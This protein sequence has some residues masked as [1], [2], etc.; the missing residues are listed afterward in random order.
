MIK[1][2]NTKSRKIFSVIVTLAILF[3]MAPVFVIDHFSGTAEAAGYDFDI[4]DLTAYDIEES[5]HTTLG[6]IAESGDEDHP[7][8]G[9]ITLNNDYQE[10]IEIPDNTVVVIDLN[11]HTLAPAGS[12]ARSNILVYGTLK[13]I[14]SAGGGMMQSDGTT[15]ISAVNVLSG[16]KLVFGGGTINNYYS[17]QNGAGIMV[18]DNGYLNMKG[19]TISH[20]KSDLQGGGI[21]AY[22]SENVD[23]SGG[24][25]IS[26]QATNGGG[27]TCYRVN[28]NGEIDLNEM[29]VSGNTATENGGGVYIEYASTIHLNRS[30]VENN[31]AQ[32]GGGL[33]FNNTTKLD[34]DDNSRIRSN[35]A[36]QSGGGIFFFAATN[37]EGSQLT[38]NGGLVN[39]NTALNGSGGGVYFHNATPKS[40]HQ[41][42][43]NGGQFN[44]NKASV[45][46]GGI[47]MY[48]KTD[49]IINNGTVNG[50]EAS[51]YGGG[52]YMEGGLSGDNCSTFTMNGGCVSENTLTSESGT[53]YG[54]GLYIGSRVTVNFNSGEISRNTNGCYGGGLYVGDYSTVDLHDGMKI[55]ENSTNI[56]NGST[57]GSGMYLYRCTLHMTGGE[58]SHNTTV[59]YCSGG[60]I[61]F[62]LGSAEI[63]GGSID[64]HTINGQGSGIYSNS[65]SLEVAGTASISDNVSKTDAGGGVFLNGGKMELYGEAVIENNQA[66]S[67]AGI[68]LYDGAF[69]IREDAAIRN[70]K[71]SGAGGGITCDRANSQ[72]H[73]K[74]GSITGNTA[75]S[76]GGLYFETRKNIGKQFRI[77]GGEI[78]GNKASNNGGGI[79]FG[80][81]G[82]NDSDGVPLPA[83]SLEIATNAVIENNTA[84]YGGGIYVS[85]CARL[86]LYEGGKIIGNTANNSGGGVYVTYGGYKYR[87]FMN[88]RDNTDGEEE[89]LEIY[90]GELHD[91]AA[92]SG[93][94]IYVSETVP[95]QRYYEVPYMAAVKA[96]KMDN[97]SSTAYW[98]D[99]TNS[100][101]ITA[102]LS[103]RSKVDNNQTPRYS[104]YTFNDAATGSAQIDNVIYPNVQAAVNAVKNNEA[105]GNDIILI[106][107]H[108]ETVVIP[109]GL[110]VSLDLNG[111]ALYGEAVSVITV[112]KDAVFTLKD[113]VGG[114]K[115]A[116]GKGTQVGTVKWG[117]GVY[118][119]GTFQ[120]E[121]GTLSHNTAGQGSAVGVNGGT[122]HMTG[123]TIENNRYDANTVTVR[124]SNGT[125]KMSD[126]VMTNNQG[127]GIYLTGTSSAEIKDTTISKGYGTY[128]AAVF[129]EGTS[130]VHID[131]C[132]FLDNTATSYYGTVY[133]SGSTVIYL[134]DTLIQGNTS[135]LGAGIYNNGGKIHLDN[136]TVTENR[137]TGDGGGLYV[138]G[139]SYVYFKNSRI[140]NNY[141]SSL[142]ADA[143]FDNSAW[144]VNE[145]GDGSDHRAVE[146][147]G[148]ENYD[149]WFD[150]LSSV[151]YVEDKEKHDSSETE[152]LN[153]EKDMINSS[154]NRIIGIHYLKAAQSPDS[155]EPVAEIVDTGVLYST[156]T[157]AVSAASKREGA[158]EIKLLKNVVEK[159]N[160]SSVSAQITLDFNGHTVQSPY[161]VSRVFY[162]THCDVHFKDTAGGGK[163]LPPENAEEDTQRQPRAIYIAGGKLT[164]EDIEIAGFC[165]T[166]NGGAIYCAAGVSA[167]GVYYPS[168]LHIKSGTI[169]NNTTTSNGGAIYVVTNANCHTVFEMTGGTI[170]NNT[171]NNGGGI[172][173]DCGTWNDYTKITISGGTFDG[174]TAKTCSGA[175]HYVGNTSANDTDEIKLYGFTMKNNQA[176]TYG[177]IYCQRGSNKNYP[178]ILGDETKKTIF[179]G[180]RSRYSYSI[181]LIY[182]EYGGTLGI[183]AQNVEIK[184]NTSDITTGSLYLKSQKVIVNNF[185]VHHNNSKGTDA[186]LIVSGGEVLVENSRFHH[187]TSRTSSAGLVIGNPENA[188]SAGD[189]LIKDCV[190]YENTA[191]SGAG[192]WD[193]SFYDTTYENCEF[194]N[195]Y[196]RENGTFMF[197]GNSGGKIRTKN[198]N[199]C[200]FHDNRA[201]GY[202]G[203]FATSGFNYAAV[204]FNHTVLENNS[205]SSRGGAIYCENSAVTY[206]I[207]EGTVIKN[208]TANEGGGICIYYG[209]LE[210][211]NGEISEN[212][213]SSNGGGIFW[214]SSN[215]N[216]HLTISGGTIS[217]NTAGSNAG[218]L[219]ASGRT[220][221]EDFK[222]EINLTGGQIINN[223]AS[224]GGGVFFYCHNNSNFIAPKVR[225]TGTQIKGNAA[226]VN[227]GGIY[228]GLMANDTIMSDNA[229]VTENTA[230]SCGGGVYVEY[231]RTDFKL[232]GGKL[233]GNRASLGNDAYII[234]NTSW[235]NSNLYLYKASE[236]F[237]DDEEYQAA[238]WIDET[239]GAVYTDVIKLRPLG[240]NYPYT[241]SYRKVNQIVA[242]YNNVEYTSVTEAIEAVTAS[243]SMSGE[244]TMVADSTESI[245]VA[246][247]VNLKL[248]LNGHTLSGGG[249]STITNRGT[250]EI[251]DDKKTVTVGDHT[252]SQSDKDG[253]IT[254]SASITGG[255]ICVK[256]GQV[257]LTGGKIADCIAGGNRDSNSYGGAA[258]GI[259][260]GEFILNGGTLCDNIAR[261]GSAVLVKTPSAT[262]TMLSGIIQNNRTS[263][264]GDST[265]VGAGGG[266]YNQGGTVNIYGGTISGNTAYQGGG[267]YSSGGKVNVTGI[268]ADEAPVIS[269]NIGG[270][271]GGGIY[272]HTGTLTASN[273]VINN[274]RTTYSKS[275][276][277]YSWQSL[278]RSAGGGIYSYNASVNISD[279]TIITQNSAVRGGGIYQY[280]GTVL[281]QGSRT[282]ITNNTAQLGGGCAQSPLPGNSST[283]MT[284]SEEA[285]VYGNRSTLTASGNDFYS[286]WEG[287]NTYKQQLGN[288]ATYTP[289]LNLIPAANMHVG[290]RY[291]VW[292]NDNYQGSS[293]TG[294]NLVSG[295][296]VVAEINMGND[297]QITAARYNADSYS[298]L[299]SEFVVKH[300]FINGVT[301]GTSNFDNGTKQSGQFLS[302]AA[303][304]EKTAKQLLEEGDPDAS[305]TDQVYYFNEEAHHYIRYQGRLYEQNQAVQWQPGSDSKKDNGIVRSF[306]KITY[307]VS[308][309]FEGDHQQE[310]YTRD[311]HCQVRIKAVLPCSMSEA[312]FDTT[313]LQNAGV[314]SSLDEH[315]N[316]VQIMTGYWKK[317]LTPAQIASGTL[318]ENIVINVKGMP[319][320]GLIQPQIEMWFDGNTTSPH[321]S[322]RAETITVSAAPKYNITVLSNPDLVHV[323]NYDMEK[324]VEVGDEEAKENDNVLNGVMLG[325]GVTVELYN[326]PTIKGLMGVEL[327][328][329]E[330]EFDL[331][332]TGKLYNSSQQV[333]ENA[334]DAPVMWAYKENN[335]TNFGRS[336]GSG[337]D[338]V[339]MSWDD[340]DHINKHS[341]YA[342]D[343]APFNNGGGVQS[344]YDGGGWIIT[345]SDQ[346]S[347]EK[348]TKY[349]VKI[350]NYQFNTDTEPTKNS[351][352]MPSTILASSA[353][354]AFSAGY[355][356]MILPFNKLDEEHKT[357][358]YYQIY[359]DAVA[360]NLKVKSVTGQIPDEVVSSSN[361]D[362]SEKVTADLDG[363]NEYYQLENSH[364]LK[365]LGYAVNERRYYDNYTNIAQALNIYPSGNGN[366][367][368]KDNIFDNAKLNHI[369]GTGYNDNGQGETPLN[370]TVFVRG[371]A[372]FNSAVIDTGDESSPYYAL[373]DQYYNTETFN[374][375]EYNYLTAVNILQKI[376]AEAYTVVGTQPIIGEPSGKELTEKLNGNF[377]IK[378]NESATTWSSTATTNYQLT[379][380]YGAKPDGKNW[381]KI[382][383]TDTTVT[384]NIHYDDGGAAD[385]DRYRE[386]NLLYFRTIDDLHEYLGD[387]AKCV[388]I[389]YQFRDC[390]IRSDHSVTAAA[391]VIVTG[392]F[393]K[394]GDTYCTT[395][396][397][398]G[399]ITYRPYYKMYYADHT[400][401]ENTYRFDWIQMQKNTD[402]QTTD[403][404]KDDYVP[405]VYGAA[406]PSGTFFYTDHPDVPEEVWKA[407]TQNDRFPIG[408]SDY[409]SGYIK[410]RYRNGIKVGGTHNGMHQ[411]NSLLLYS[412]DTS[413]DLNVETKV[414]GTNT[415]K[416][417]YIITYGERE[418]QYRVTPHISIAS[419]ASKTTLTRN[420]TQSADITI[421]LKIPDGLHYQDG[422]VYIDYSFSD[423]DEGELQWEITS[424][425][426]ET[427]TTVV[428]L[429]TFV[430]DIDK[431]LPEIFYDCF[432]GDDK[433]PSKDIKQSGITLLSS[434][435]IRAKY[436]E[437]NLLAAE[438]HTDTASITV[439]KVSQEGISKT[440]G[441]RMT[442]LG[443]DINYTVTYANS[444]KD[445]SYHI[446][447]ADVLPHNSDGRGTDFNGG[448]R[449]KAVTIQFT[450]EDDCTEF[451]EQGVL[452]FGKD[453][454]QWNK[455]LSENATALNAIITAA[456]N[457]PVTAS[458][459]RSGTKSVVYD[460]SALDVMTTAYADTDEPVRSAPVLYVYVP[461]VS[462]ESRFFV[463]VTLTPYQKD[464]PTAL[465]QSGSDAARSKTQIGGDEYHNNFVYRK[466]IGTNKYSVPLVSN[467]VS[468]SVINRSVS[469]VVWMDQDHNGLYNTPEWVAYNNS[470]EGAEPQAVEYPV[471]HI[472]VTLYNAPSGNAAPTAAVNILGEPVAPVETD[473]N[474]KYEFENLA[475]GE[476][477]VVFNDAANQYQFESPDPNV[478]AQPLAFDKLSVTTD[479][480]AQAKR[481]NQCVAVYDAS[482]P[483]K[484]LSGRLYNTTIVLPD[485]TKI[486]TPQY[487]SPDWNLGLYYD[488]IT[489]KKQWDNMIYGI[490]DH[491]TIVFDITG[492]EKSSEK[493][494]YN[495][496]LEISN[497]SGEVKA[498]YTEKGQTPV[499][500]RL[501]LTEDTD[502]HIVRWD[503]AEDDRIY[504][505]SENAHG[506]INYLFKETKLE[507]NGK[508]VS[509]FYHIFEKDTV[510]AVT[511]KRICQVIN[512]QILGSVTILKRDAAN[513]PLENAEFSIY[514]TAQKKDA[515]DSTFYG[516]KQGVGT[517]Y[518]DSNLY[519]VQ[520]TQLYYKVI[521]GDKTVL[522]ALEHLGMYNA[523]TN[524]LSIEYGEN[525]IEDVKVHKE[526]YEGTTR[527][528]YYTVNENQFTYELIFGGSEEYH[529]LVDR[530]IIDENDKYHHSNGFVYSVYRRRVDGE[531]EYYVKVTVD[532]NN[533]DKTAIAEF[534]NL[535]LYSRE[536]SPIYYTVRETCEPDGYIA[537]ADFNLLTGMDLY[538]GTV[539][540]AGNAVHDF[541]FEVENTKQMQLP[542]TGEHGMDIT[543]MFGAVLVTLGGTYLLWFVLYKRKKK[544]GCVI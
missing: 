245:A 233:Y 285:S 521:L 172:Y 517:D 219:Y 59:N 86:E 475:P 320:G 423:Y 463:T 134:K 431:V 155:S 258:V 132:Q 65:A 410:S 501:T 295:Q 342:Y 203:A 336:I 149:C 483:S 85:D 362:T 305:L 112:E 64:H 190:F 5:I 294:G 538:D 504:L 439:L 536:G 524:L 173:F 282:V 440:A 109:E 284:L 61:Y 211:K 180:N 290:K 137:S 317:T 425:T 70:N 414:S 353:V 29:T 333:V 316:P 24:T 150:E 535:P 496:L 371:N 542:V 386:E 17:S 309:A 157:A 469:G 71:A 385:M 158:V 281:I 323:G 283:V 161:G 176:Y 63:T 301:D 81:V 363:M 136:V 264:Y 354:K 500:K 508:D 277:V 495:A 376:D 303:P 102:D 265:T 369:N 399:W 206:M 426:D 93:R 32:N 409:T 185:D 523:K 472:T 181:G 88:A 67:A 126:A 461:Q 129:A 239:T 52:L 178:L 164:I 90:G 208:N 100:N 322:C 54:S 183:L 154:N 8:C 350:S 2:Q 41:L 56:A 143:R 248:N 215:T 214:H 72:F 346:P 510:D 343:C 224:N 182:N 4:A 502:K 13:L 279:G 499:E 57:A 55:T 162:L 488:D 235:R 68:R 165:F 198:I 103:N 506:E 278:A 195:N 253:K 387:D 288:N 51:R 66:S 216:S 27:I 519:S 263:R 424:E 532:P 218:G 529:S 384:P 147:F 421:M 249:T 232:N 269:E 25:V 413:V 62:Y 128:T 479:I 209:N 192:L 113:S 200:H 75:S 432:I 474:G 1:K 318:S 106:K 302:D 497:N 46:G 436:S 12:T 115:V 58:I 94:D 395:N 498:M 244:V 69:E 234:Y 141:A 273:A 3:N 325:F 229:V 38:L 127:R 76:G 513:A 468:T 189:K 454:A 481:G 225:V 174:N 450:S 404:T 276:D 531:R 217:N 197:S 321:C 312:N 91:N 428:Y 335:D 503:I 533:F 447:A 259:E 344:C 487:T 429:R 184:E 188:I 89:A 20:C 275:A 261:Y 108:R 40:R 250:L 237:G 392:D 516:A 37:Y 226:K 10:N 313:E 22:L 254:G 101:H 418:V 457:E 534:L 116:D 144:L 95:D 489:V 537:L 207:D 377:D 459:T 480:N 163:I 6:K 512:S 241:L 124:V 526:L 340:E 167:N 123:G 446:E 415:V 298:T 360:S 266:I 39:E 60:G 213:A 383:K 518:T 227:G 142:G 177:A 408:L 117:G 304:F 99:E 393:E 494:V 381:I 257:T 53:R 186:A 77:T 411:G 443:E 379:I 433:D 348:E 378:I 272:V 151:Y 140:Y 331:S 515:A 133:A 21:Y 256:S 255:G 372:Y 310:E 121:G 374:I 271:N 202:G 441:D 50:N 471:S 427:G 84:N 315:G 465:I 326:D 366:V 451:I 130:T 30:V 442:E 122:F 358:G 210:V 522:A 205:A 45:N 462:G 486:P 14:D 146:N 308:Y 389:L 380:L 368:N 347:G 520:S 43:L 246:S 73:M 267:I 370:S 148:L 19:G 34:I 455:T 274:N 367:I 388:A 330:L 187:N 334:A 361:L 82:G 243:D 419:G 422:S 87:N 36:S 220:T 31:T 373:N 300:L 199:H 299:D 179:S 507:A 473:E 23:F 201:L 238:G 193:A 470:L 401:A 242:V 449:V 493:T 296:F 120:M 394:V 9:M 403:S 230:G 505:P 28:K 18:E 438:T 236:M 98:I 328:D 365:T 327:P 204:V 222:I 160:F 400:Q 97:A 262:F 280:N 105:P 49:C 260:G 223:L 194:Y 26:N 114:G 527:Y 332:F 416:E 15:D 448:Y 135:S 437:T 159:I 544:G 430:S 92:L 166:G 364:Q 47:W 528:Y 139:N 306:D 221:V 286:A 268:S 351:G 540:T 337:L 125:I 482:D 341:H 156:L 485:K 324:M 175:V 78:S 420:G 356:Q 11:G 228:N 357:S 391:K 48:N 251:V 490:P 434:A 396:D 514:Q 345:S 289:R 168:E 543:I 35:T 477:I 291:N 104:I 406:L 453:N 314:V 458:S 16:G 110:N 292:K 152:F 525:S 349:H 476:Y 145:S 530:G 119:L 464:E 417:N 33:Y 452:G 375:I 44:G 352:N 170:A 460:F 196:A 492:K 467:S 456:A 169:Q 171:A 402:Q 307:V 491:T 511:Q 212:K 390:V 252:Y 231:G 539:D 445:P 359:M 382:P 7:G 80:R 96:S 397:V 270:F 541:C 74:G 412:I 355:I 435:E 240:R 338:I 111:L 131:G 407:Y 118:V 329:K 484:L 444:L 405:P 398:R 153:V 311:Y 42:T 509:E 466:I 339:N 319:N 293:R 478:P 297:I 138:N 79:C 287:T 247:G 107:S 191:S 83:S